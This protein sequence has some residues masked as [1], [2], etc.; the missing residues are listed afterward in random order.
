[1]QLLPFPLLYDHGRR[2]QI[3]VLFPCDSHQLRELLEAL[4]TSQHIHT[5]CNVHRTPA[6]IITASATATPAPEKKP[7]SFDFSL[8]Y[9]F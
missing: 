5:A 4:H 7:T 2:M 9:H 1:M 6:P 8:R 3:H